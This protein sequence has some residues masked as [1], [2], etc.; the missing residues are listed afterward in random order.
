MVLLF[1]PPIDVSPDAGPDHLKRVYFYPVTLLVP[2][3]KI[4]YFSATDLF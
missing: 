1:V 2:Y 4:A 3:D